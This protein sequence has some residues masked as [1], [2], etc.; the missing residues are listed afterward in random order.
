MG[1]NAVQSGY[2][3][4]APK[5]PTP[6]FLDVLAPFHQ[7]CHVPSGVETLG[8]VSSSAEEDGTAPGGDPAHGPTSYCAVPGLARCAARLL[9]GGA[10]P[11]AC[12]VR[13]IRD[14]HP[15]TKVAME[16]CRTFTP[17][18]VRSFAIY[19]DGSA[20]AGRAAWGGAVI[21]AHHDGSFSL[22]AT[23]AQD[24]AEEQLLLEVLGEARDNNTAEHVGVAWAMVLALRL[25]ACFTCRNYE[26]WCDNTAAVMAAAGKA[27]SKPHLLLNCTLLA[28]ADSVRDV[29]GPL[30]V[31]HIKGHAGHPWNELAD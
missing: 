10:W 23:Y 24:L 31:N 13:G 16:Q 30:A 15:F 7:A 11:R 20:T 1:F 6:I 22:F 9:H 21:A 17:Y 12:D 14:L 5:F 26:I 3:E 18:D 25:H 19:V 4:L 2:D 27:C 28:M 29:M 8:G